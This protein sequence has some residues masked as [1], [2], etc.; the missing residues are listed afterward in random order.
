ML[1]QVRRSSCSII[2]NWS[3]IL[4]TDYQRNYMAEVQPACVS[5]TAVQPDV[6][7]SVWYRP[8]DAYTD[9]Q[10]SKYWPHLQK[11]NKLNEQVKCL[12][13]IEDY[14]IVPT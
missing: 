11:H 10:I 7:L 3:Y 12:I 9:I 5:L 13:T 6:C 2:T 8:T 4:P 1:I 14:F